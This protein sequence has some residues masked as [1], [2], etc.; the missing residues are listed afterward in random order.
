MAIVVCCPACKVRLTMGDDRAGDRIDCPNC[1]SPI[2][3]PGPS[4]A[5]P[6]IPSPPTPAPLPPAPPSPKA[7]GPP[8]EFL[9]PHCRSR[10]T[11]ARKKAGTVVEC[12]RCN[13]RVTVPT[14]VEAAPE[15]ILIDE[16]SP[17]PPPIDFDTH[18]VPPPLPPPLHDDEDPTPRRRRPARLQCPYCGS[19]TKAIIRSE[20]S[21]GGWIVFVVLLIVFFPLCWIAGFIRQESRVCRDCGTVWARV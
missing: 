12:P 2:R 14:P 11:I 1:D 20:V 15:G 21:T 13:G 16:P 9:C 7:G 5:P 17:T 19:T 3:I 4:P 10:L 8:I 6:P 18:P